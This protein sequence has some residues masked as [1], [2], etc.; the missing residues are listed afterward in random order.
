MHDG[1]EPH[2]ILLEHPLPGSVL[3]M[4]CSPRL[5]RPLISELI[6]IF[7]ST[8]LMNRYTTVRIFGAEFDTPRQD[9]VD[10]NIVIIYFSII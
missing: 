2:A 7:D 9:S 4:P 10:P 5:P 8:I 6:R 3:P 1:L